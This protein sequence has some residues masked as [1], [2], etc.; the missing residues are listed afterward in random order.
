VSAGELVALRCRPETLTTLAEKLTSFGPADGAP[1]WLVSGVWLCADEAPFVATASLEVLSDGYVARPLSIYS[2]DDLVAHIET[3]LP[4]I[5]GRLVARGSD[6]ELPE[7]SDAPFAPRLLKTWPAGPYSTHVL[8]RA[9]QRARCVH[10]IAC[11]VLFGTESGRSLLVG[12]DLAMLA[13]VLSEDADLIKR[14]RRGCEALTP[15]EYL[16]RC[17]N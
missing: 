5:S 11:A 8:L 12:T 7:T 17:C 15:A 1:K 10:H 9:S 13:M 2:P 14:Y 4:D 16:E 3:E 6:V